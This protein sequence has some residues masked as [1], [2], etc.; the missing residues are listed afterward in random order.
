MI[1]KKAAFWASA[2]VLC[3]I[4]VIAGAVLSPDVVGLLLVLASFVSL[5]II[6]YNTVVGRVQ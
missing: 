4:A 1:N 2:V 6:V 3:V 5:W